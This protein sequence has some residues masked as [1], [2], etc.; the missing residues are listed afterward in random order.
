MVIHVNW[1]ALYTACFSVPQQ[2]IVFLKLTKHCLKWTKSVD[3]FGPKAASARIL[4]FV[5]F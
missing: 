3:L 2:K 1:N 4:L 5:F